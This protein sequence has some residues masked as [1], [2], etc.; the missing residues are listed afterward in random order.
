MNS[1]ISPASFDTNKKKNKL[2]KNIM[3]KI[4]LAA[5]VIFTMGGN[6]KA[7]ENVGIG[8]NKPNSSA[9]LDIQSIDKG[10]LIPRLT[11]EQRSLITAPADGL[12]IYQT[13]SNSGFYYYNGTLKKWSA[14]S[15]QDANSIAAANPDNWSLTGNAATSP[16][17]N[18]IGTTDLQSLR[19]KVG[20]VNSGLIDLTAQQL[21]YFGYG[22]GQNNSTGNFNTG[23]GFKTL[24][25]NTTGN[26]NVAIGKQSLLVS[27]G[28]FNSGMGSNTLLSNT[29]GSNNLAMGY[30]ALQSNT[31]GN[32]NTGIGFGSLFHN[33]TGS[34]NVAIG[35]DAGRFKNGT[36]N[37]YIGRQA[38]L[39]SSL[40]TEDNS[41]YISNSSTENPLIKG[42]FSQN[43]LKINSK[44]TGYLAVG[45]FDAGAPMPT[46]TGYR[47]IVQDGILTEK[48]K[49][50]VKTTI[51]WADYVFEDN[52]KLMP[53]SEVEQYTIENK[54]LPNVPSAE[55]MSKDGLD[56]GQTSKMFMEKIE[57]LTL[58]II[59]LNKEIESLKKK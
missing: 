4:L 20:N 42:N 19:F 38:G 5:S 30:A 47:L 48:V 2:N 6:L 24:N 11:L 1:I 13:N 23:I 45:D 17:T 8:T 50:A 37:I 53:L 44:T 51:D 16:G 31:T 10:L 25:S 52:Y 15:S 9:I 22:S 28:S 14:L 54:H 33:T 36:G 34:F 40:T 46:P 3:K 56:I 21:T 7:Q 29:T 43:T 49:V 55:T 27:N 12:M 59:Q 18:F 35:P 58:Y 26:H 41:L 32:Q 57:E 39:A